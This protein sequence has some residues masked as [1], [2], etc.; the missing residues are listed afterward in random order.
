MTKN[1]D[2]TLAEVDSIYVDVDERFVVSLVV[3][4]GKPDNGQPRDGVSTP[5]EAAAAALDLT[6]DEGSGDTV[7]FVHDRTTG[8]THQFEQ[9][10]FEEVE[11]P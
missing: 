7:W 11:V 6:R 10:D 5:E 2:F 3:G 9:E 1:G 8:R 4:Y